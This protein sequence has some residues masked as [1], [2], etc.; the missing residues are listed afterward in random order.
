MNRHKIYRLYASRPKA[1][2]QK[3]AFITSAFV[4]LFSGFAAAAPLFLSEK[5]YAGNLSDLVIN[6]VYTLGN[7]DWIELYNKGNSKITPPQ[8]KELKLK[9][10]T[11]VFKT[12][13]EEEIN[14]KEYF[15]IE[16]GDRLNNGGDSVTL[17]NKQENVLDTVTYGPSANLIPTSDKSLGRYPN[18][19]GD[20]QLM[21]PTKGAENIQETSEPE[22]NPIIT[23]L[24]AYYVVDK[25]Q[26]IG[27]DIHVDDLTD[28]TE[29]KVEVE[30]TNG[31]TVTKTNKAGG[32][33]LTTLN[34]GNPAKVTAPIVIQQGSYDEAGS[35]SWNQPSATWDH[36]TVPTKITVT[37][38]RAGGGTLV[39]S[40]DIDQ[41]GTPFG[42]LAEVMP[43]APTHPDPDN[44]HQM[45]VSGLVYRDHKLDDCF[46]KTSC[47]DWAE[48][49]GAGWEINMYKETDGGTWEFIK[50][51]QTNTDGK[52]TFSAVKD[53]GTY[54][55]CQ[56][57]QDGWTQQ[58]QNWSGTPYH[59]ATTNLSGND[60][61]GPYCR[62]INYS[63]TGNY[64]TA[65][66]FGNVD[67]AKPEGAIVYSGGIDIN[68]VRYIKSIDDLSFTGDFSD[69]YLLNR[70]TYVV[71]S[72][73]SEFKNRV[74]Y[75]GGWGAGANTNLPLSGSSDT[76]NGNVKDCAPSKDWSDGFYEIGHR[77]YDRAGNYLGLNS[78]TQ[79][80]VIDGTAPSIEFISP[81]NGSTHRGTVTVTIKGQDDNGIKKIALYIHS[82]ETDAKVA[83]FAMRQSDS[84]PEEWHAEIDTTKFPDGVY[85][86]SARAVDI[87]N[88]VKYLN[89]RRDSYSFTIDNTAPVASITAPDTDGK[90]LSGTI[91]VT[92]EVNTEEANI[93]SHWFEITNPDGSKSHVHNLNTSDK[94]YSFTLDTSFGDGEYKIRYVATDK[95][96]N[97]SDDPGFSNPTIRTLIV[98]NT[99]PSKPEIIKPAGGQY[100]S[101][102]PIR[103]EWT[104]SSDANG[105][106][107]YLVEYIYDDGHTFAGG[108]Y[109]EVA[110][111]VTFRNHTPALGEQG[112][113][114]IRVQAIDNAGNASEWSEQVHYFYDATEPDAPIIIS[115]ANNAFVNGASITQSWSSASSDVAYYLYESYNDEGLTDLRWRENIPA[116]SKT[117]INVGNAV[118]WWRV[119]AVDHAGNE[120]DW[121]EVWKITVDNDAPVASIT[122]HADDTRVNDTVVLVGEVADANPMNTHFLITGPDGY[123]KTST[124]RDGRTEHEFTWDT[125]GLTDGVY[126]VQFEVRDKAGNKTGASVHAITII[127]DNTGPAVTLT[128]PS[129]G[130]VLDGI[131]VTQVWTTDATDVD[132]YIY[133]SF[134]DAAMTDPL[135]I[136]EQL[137]TSSRV[138]SNVGEGTYYWQVMAVDTLG[139]E[140]PWSDLWQ[141]TIDNEE[142][143]VDQNVLAFRSDSNQPPAAS[144]PNGPSSNPLIVRLAAT[145]STPDIP[146]TPESEQQVE[147]ATADGNVLRLQTPNTP[148]DEQNAVI[149]QISDGSTSYVW[150]W[151]GLGAAILAA[152]WFVFF[153]RRRSDQRSA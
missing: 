27:V 95:A 55:A 134:R 125:N 10:D 81:A 29:V 64:S 97:R 121:S 115:P 38:T 16:V 62:T 46:G 25:Y 119:K 139:N 113:V 87:A 77:A 149:N 116:T 79:K 76:V 88:N 144:T 136:D 133:R 148:G 30:R 72:V 123:R 124:F 41:V 65:F 19:T 70:T 105:I 66:Y 31:G 56:V 48:K 58:T 82:Q 85:N 7:N 12:L 39:K 94:S 2:W 1:F 14:A 45:T 91:T 99:A 109:R 21:P 51:A 140:G 34:T 122:S 47:E 54:Y 33:V 128:S 13:P 73:N 42:T 152:L 61:E 32:S 68:G 100:F 40:V 138:T 36:T 67:T 98:D 78:P 52:F 11:G 111:N 5:V 71:W 15:V 130:A 108:P 135:I 147:I 28:A 6:E 132:H 112:G 127:V 96:G 106:S 43:E 59:I 137:A 143:S 153:G 60:A 74:S 89:N 126:T 114:K 20:F 44:K 69:N 102:T 18:G 90:I 75:C 49:L 80:F 117:A 3:T 8:L 141:I 142:E 93:K 120:S 146:S 86:L 145:T 24:E 63:D 84:N 103:N 83:E 35:S 118:Y 17:L 26:G 129:N 151:L 4:L 57:M 110:G 104:A 37:I 92:G 107:K 50:S 22:T 101:S 23:K 131:T 150:L 53:A 9:D